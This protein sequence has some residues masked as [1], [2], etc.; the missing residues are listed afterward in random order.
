MS[1]AVMGSSYEIHMRTRQLRAD[2]TARLG[3][4]FSPH[5]G[6]CRDQPQA[7]LVVAVMRASSPRWTIICCTTLGSCARTLPARCDLAAEGFS[8][9]PFARCQGRA[10]Q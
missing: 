9:F 10:I 3:T 5:I 6:S 4:D 8:E 7:P 1:A 2:E